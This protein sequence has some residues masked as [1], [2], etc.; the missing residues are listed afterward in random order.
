MSLGPSYS[1]LD[2]AL[3]FVNIYFNR[4]SKLVLC[5]LIRSLRNLWTGMICALQLDSDERQK[6]S[7]QSSSESVL[8][9]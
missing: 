9:M 7:P 5:T 1:S 8:K 2:S 4:R 6:N 3:L